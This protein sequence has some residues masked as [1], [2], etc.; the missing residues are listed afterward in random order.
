MRGI[1]NI[2]PLIVFLF[3]GI[4]VKAQDKLPSI[5]DKFF[6]KKLGVTRIDPPPTMLGYG[7]KK[8]IYNS[9]NGTNILYRDVIFGGNEWDSCNLILEKTSNLL[10]S[11]TFIEYFGYFGDDDADDFFEEYKEKIKERYGAPLSVTNDKN[12]EKIITYRGSNEIILILAKKFDRTE[13]N[14]VSLMYTDYHIYERVT[15]EN[16][17]DL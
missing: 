5:Q 16:L 7:I 10:Y 12:F 14:S 2:L 15:K 4:G 13:G 17:Y 8:D 9:A 6:G 3:I 11:I 1:K